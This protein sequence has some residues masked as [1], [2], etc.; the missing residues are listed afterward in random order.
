M[1]KEENAD[2]VSSQ[3][4]IVG[5]KVARRCTKPAGISGTA[6]RD[7]MTAK[8]PSRAAA[9]ANSP[10]VVADAQPYLAPS[11]RV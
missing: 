7:S 3:M 4:E 9:T 11:S 5:A 8:A 10:R 1:K 2:T 6:A